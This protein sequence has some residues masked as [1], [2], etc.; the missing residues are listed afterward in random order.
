[1]GYTCQ[2]GSHVVNRNRIFKT[3]SHSPTGLP[4]LHSSRPQCVVV[5]VSFYTCLVFFIFLHKLRRILSL[6]FDA[7]LKNET[8]C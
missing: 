6:Q 1:M 3:V 2:I 4:C 8:I 7:V 5:V